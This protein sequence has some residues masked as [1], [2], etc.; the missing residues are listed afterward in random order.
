[1]YPMYS[2]YPKFDPQDEMVEQDRITMSLQQAL[3]DTRFNHQSPRSVDEFA[4]SSI[5]TIAFSM[6]VANDLN[7]TPESTSEPEVEP[8]KLK[9]SSRRVYKPIKP[10]T[11]PYSMSM[12]DEI[13]TWLV[14]Y[15]M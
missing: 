8:V 3:F 13:D 9:G 10:I 11:T 5:W 15:K 1:M 6:D 2:L 4:I 14:E 7:L 12:Q